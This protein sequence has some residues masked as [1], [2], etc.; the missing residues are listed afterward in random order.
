MICPYC[1]EEIVDGALKCKHCNSIL[2]EPPKQ[3]QTAEQSQSQQ[4]RIK[5]VDELSLPPDIKQKLQFVQDNY[6]RTVFGLPDY[7][8]KGKALWQTFNIWAFLFNCI[9]Y[10][11]KG[12]WR[13]GLLLL[14]MSVAITVISNALNL[15][16]AL[17]FG[18]SMLIPI[19]AMQSAYYDLY[20]KHVRSEIF[21]W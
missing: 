2:T 18:I 6:K 12:M 10:F 19:I 1:K 17:S 11:A 15:P 3:P 16:P 4:A 5:S 8:L 9:Y 7:G 13:K 20:R 21:W 14:G